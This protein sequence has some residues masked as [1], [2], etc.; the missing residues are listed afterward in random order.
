MA[1]ANAHR[2]RAVKR[3]FTRHLDDLAMAETTVHLKL[4][5]ET[6]LALRVEAK[7]ID[8]KPDVSAAKIVAAVVEHDLYVAVLGR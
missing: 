3:E 7:R 5:A 2:D 4:P 1:P 8:I 6:V